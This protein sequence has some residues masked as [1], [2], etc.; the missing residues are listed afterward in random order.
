MRMLAVSG[1]GRN[2]SMSSG[3]QI[4]AGTLFSSQTCM[5]PR[6]NRY[7]TCVPCVGGLVLGLTVLWGACFCVPCR[8]CTAGSGCR[9]LLPCLA[10]SRSALQGGML[11]G[12]RCGLCLVSPRPCLWRPLVPRPSLRRSTVAVLLWSFSGCPSVSTP[13]C[14]CGARLVLLC[15]WGLGR[16]LIAT[17]F[18]SR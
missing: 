7:Q 10:T 6:R 3:S 13:S 17:R 5:P 14:S 18:G 8:L 15:L 2:S 11:C 9:Y 1:I 4:R 12:L 16:V